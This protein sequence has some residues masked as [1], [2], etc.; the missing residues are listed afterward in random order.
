[1]L[2][3]IDHERYGEAS[4]WDSLEEAADDI[5]GNCGPEFEKTE[6]RLGAFDCWE[7][8]YEVLD[9]RDDVVGRAFA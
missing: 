4:E 6:F 3:I 5:R 8:H 7:G 2:V 1:M 9:D